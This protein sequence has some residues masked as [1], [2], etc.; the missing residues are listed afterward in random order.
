MKKLLTLLF[1]VSVVLSAPNS[2]SAMDLKV[3]GSWMVGGHVTDG[4]HGDTFTAHHVA[5]LNL[6]I[7]VNED[8]SA[9]IQLQAGNSRPYTHTLFWGDSGVGGPGTPVS[10][11]MA[12]L[13]WR[14]P[15]T[16]VEVRMGRQL[17]LLSNYVFRSP[18]FGRTVDSV[19]V[20]T[21]LNKK[22][23][24]N[25][26]WL[27]PS[28]NL[29]KW[30]TEHYPHSSVDLVFLKADLKEDG[31]KIS[32][33]GMIGQHGNGIKSRDTNG[34]PTYVPD[35]DMMGYGYGSSSIPEDLGAHT[36]VYWAGLGGELTMFAP[37]RFTTDILYR[38]NDAGGTAARKGWYAALG[39]EMKTSWGTPFLQGW[40]ASGDDADSKGSNRMLSFRGRF[41]HSDIY[42]DPLSMLFPYSP[43]QSAAGLWGIRFGVKEVSFI[44]DLNHSLM[45]TYFQGTY[46]TN[47]VTDDSVSRPADTYRTPIYYMTT[48][49]S[50]WEINFL[51]H[52]KLYQNLTVRPQFV[53][54]ITN[55]DENIR[56]TRY[57][58]LFRASL[59]FNW[60]N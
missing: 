42:S 35:D 29:S 3:S 58:N 50:A 8:V 31:Y 55:F 34:K 45:V 6:D 27:R 49:D 52:Y 46:N 12:H 10:V 14:V 21:P 47:R 17:L 7:N 22:V 20:H 9:F 1:A 48:A 59:T 26:G 60:M 23:S 33:W 57:H 38:A 11:P 44:D 5:R 56:T 43:S 25:A 2:A 16:D 39:A 4:F 54:L 32:H 24:L 30:G 15:S 37:F 51:T 40:Y 18:V 13:A 41:N 28:A 53:Y 19:M 36:T